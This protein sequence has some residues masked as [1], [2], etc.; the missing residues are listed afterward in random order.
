M[1]P[2][3][4]RA[5][6]LNAAANDPHGDHNIIMANDQEVGLLKRLG[7]AGVRNPQTGFLQF[8]PAGAMGG[9]SD[10]GGDRNGPMGRGGEGMGHG[11]PGRGG[12]RSNDAGFSNGH[13]YGAGT[14]VGGMPNPNP[15]GANSPT[16]KALAAQGANVNAALQSQHDYV[17]ASQAFAN[18]SFG[19]KLI[20]ALAGM[21]P[22]LGTQKPTLGQPNSYVGGTYHNTLNPAGLAGGALGIAS[23]IPGL[24][25]LGEQAF[26]RT[27]NALGG[28]NYSFGG[29]GV[30]PQTGQSTGSS[31]SGGNTLGFG[32]QNSPSN[33][34]HVGQGAAGNP[35]ANAINQNQ[36][37]QQAALA[38]STGQSGSVGGVPG[39]IG[40]LGMQQAPQSGMVAPGYGYSLPGYGYLA[41]R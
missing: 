40:L 29:P 17:N 2:V 7:G 34:S 14:T 39:G 13:A 25:T 36:I 32:G 37:G 19:D 15:Y 9:G 24:G 3:K 38:A 16:G 1:K 30:D 35:I 4:T 12:G 11:D 22:G 31:W 23:G 33:V 20:G 26:G 8:Y 27:Y 6:L 21:I 10:P 18:R 28:N 41:W 5:G